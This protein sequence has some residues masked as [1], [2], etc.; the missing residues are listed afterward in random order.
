MSESPQPSVGWQ[1]KW[2]W[3]GGARNAV[4]FHF[5]ARKTFD[6]PAGPSTAALH[7]CA[8]SDYVLYVNGQ[9]VARGPLPCDPARP[10]HDTHDV[11]RLLRA[12]PNA[13]AVLC[14]NWGVGNHWHCRGPGGL[15]AQLEVRTPV[16]DALVCTDE[17]WRV[18]RAEC[19]R[20]NSPRV[21]WSAGFM[22]TFDFRR[23]EAGWVRADFDD[24]AWEAPEVIGRHP[25]GPWAVLEP[26]DI[27]LLAERPV[28]AQSMERGRFKLSGVHA[29]GFGKLLPPGRAGLVYAETLVHAAE[30]RQVILRLICDD[31]CKAFLDGRCVLEQNYNE[32]FARS[33]VWRGRDEYEQ[34]HYGMTGRHGPAEAPLRLDKG[35]HRLTIVA[36]QSE[37]GWG[38]VLM[39]LD[40]RTGEVL[41]LPAAAEGGQAGQWTIAGPLETTGMNDSLDAAASSLAE[42]PSC[43]RAQIDPFAY[44]DVTDVG[45]LLASERRSGFAPVDPAE[46]TELNEGDCCIVDLGAVWAGYTELEIDSGAEAILDLGCGCFLG[47]DRR[48]RH[49]QGGMLRCSDRLYVA[50]GRHLWQP[51]HRRTGRYVHVSCRRGGP[52][53]ICRAGMVSCGYPVRRQ[54]EFDCPD[55]PL[56][57]VWETS[58]HTTALLMQYGYQDCLRREQGTLNQ[59][60]FNYASRAAACCFGDTLLARR[61]LRMAL[62]TQHDDGWLDGHGI[63][64]PNR[65]DMTQALYWAVWLHDYLLYSGDFAFAAEAFEGLE[66]NLR[67]FSKAINRRGLLDGANWPLF[68]TGQLVY[69]DDACSYMEG[70]QYT[71]LSFRESEIFGLNVLFFAAL[72]AAGR[73]ADAL[74]RPAR[75]VWYRRRAERV[76]R[77]CNGRFWDERRGLYAEWVLRGRRCERHHPVVQIMA[78]YFGLCDERQGGRLMDW[79]VGELGLPGR[80]RPD[81]PLTTFGIYYYFLEVLFRGGHDELALELMRRVHGSWVEAGGTAF[82]EFYRVGEHNVGGR[83]DHEFEVHGYGTSAHLHFYANIL[84]VRPVEPGFARVRVAPRPGGLPWASGRIATVRGPIGVSWRVAGGAIDLDVALPPGCRGDVD[85]PPA[86]RAGRVNVGEAPR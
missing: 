75:A 38:F 58:V 15:I 69:I 71:D 70:G 67:F 18:R 80:D 56:K 7:I 14:H 42:L 57:R 23:G 26:R 44:G 9:Y 1:A 63:S 50:P 27:P 10:M 37:V 6:L 3:Y 39:F 17:T 4:N 65:D 79:L 62:R 52:V 53:R 5:H 66:D 78:L 31:A 60:S 24:S 68:R 54:A 51:L 2:L 43:A 85:L 83:L 30:D 47:D 41:D 49:Y 76:A 74:G 55:A 77:S 36:D 33:R 22:E 82:P 72:A 40:A 25:A 11:S 81:Y 13:I 64:S 46:G 20:P 32:E 19:Y 28:A 12:G 73:L 45:T 61:A 35:D 59:S 8:F 16:G 29:V 84:G 34:V 86:L 21:F 48:L